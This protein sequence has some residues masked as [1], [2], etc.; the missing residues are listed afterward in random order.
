MRALT[1]FKKRAFSMGWAWLI[2]AALGA[3]LLNLL[4]MQGANAKP[5]ASIA[6]QK[7]FTSYYRGATVFRDKNSNRQLDEGKEKRTAVRSNADGSFVAPRGRGRL[8]LIEGTHIDTGERNTLTLTAPPQARALGTLTSLWQALLE[9]RQSQSKIKK[10]LGLSQKYA[11]ADFRAIPVSG[12]KAKQKSLIQADAKLDT[13]VRFLR[14][15]TLGAANP[16]AKAAT[17]SDQPSFSEIKGT[18][19][20]LQKTQKLK[21]KKPVN[22][23][24]QVTNER[25]LGEAAKQLELPLTSEQTSKIAAEAKTLN[26]DIDKN[27]GSLATILSNRSCLVEKIPNVTSGGLLPSA[28]NFEVVA[29]VDGQLCH[30]YRDNHNSGRQWIPTACFGENADSA[31]ALIQGSYGGEHGNFEVAFRNSSNQ[32]CHWYRD[33]SDSTNPNPPWTISY[34]FN[35]NAISAPALIQSNYGIQGNLEVIFQNADNQLC[36]WFRDD[37][38]DKVWNGPSACFGESVSSAPSLI[39]SDYVNGGENGNFEAVAQVGSQLCHW[40][41]DNSDPLNPAPPWLGPTCFGNNVSPA[42][43]LIQSNYGGAHGNF[44]VIAQV[45]TQVCHW[46]RDNSDPSN[47]APPWLGGP[48]DDCFG[49]SV[50]S[51]PSLIQSSYGG[52][53]GNFEAVARVGSQLCHWYRDNST[54]PPEWKETECFGNNV[55]SAPALIQSNY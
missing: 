40:Y 19:V 33:N 37:D 36:L 2:R 48:P 32:L 38:V 17:G 22:L 31:P 44:E 45:G 18:A 34:C 21:P 50:S 15:L 10:Q 39:Q 8:C 30:W 23:A 51:A 47:P 28:C 25:V 26:E 41:R 3:A 55:D 29:Q 9:R 4:L 54:D 13:L 16:S 1:C 53:H 49:N 12:A 20:A 7:T 6:S 52:D 5:S 24:E 46:Y 42:P 35:A 11:L 43:S 14:S 27:P